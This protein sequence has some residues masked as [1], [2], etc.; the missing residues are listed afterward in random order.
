MLHRS[1]KSDHSSTSSFSA[2]NPH[3]PTASVFTPP[4]Y[5]TD[6]VTPSPCKSSASRKSKRKFP[7]FSGLRK[8]LSKRRSEK[9]SRR[10]MNNR[11][12]CGD[13][14]DEP[15]GVSPSGSVTSMPSCLPFPWFGER[16]RDK[17]EEGERGRERL[18][19]VSSSSL[20]YLTTT[21]RRDQSIGSPVGSSSMVGHVSD[22]SLSGHS[23]NFTF[24]STETLD[25]DPVPTNNN[26]QWQS[27]PALEWNNQQV[28]L[29]LIAMNMDQYTAEFAARGVDGTQLLN[30]DSEK[31]K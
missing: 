14:V 22:H 20:P 3:P 29:W 1:S 11:G 19:S 13:L 30:M 18:R 12:S 10:S 26:N 28:C 2:L 5:I 31:L 21:G 24:S 8:S 27:R 17:E 9:H 16:G 7:D 25:D 15:A 6:T 23:H 4:N